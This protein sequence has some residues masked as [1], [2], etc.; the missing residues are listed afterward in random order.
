MYKQINISVKAKESDSSDFWQCPIA[1][2]LPIKGSREIVIQLDASEGSREAI[3]KELAKKIA[4]NAFVCALAALDD[5]VEYNSL[6]EDEKALIQ[7]IQ[8]F[9]GQ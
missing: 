9:S 2:G 6:I 1:G 3:L 4:Y 7:E 8:K 5:S